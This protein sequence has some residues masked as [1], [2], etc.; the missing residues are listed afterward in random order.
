MPTMVFRFSMPPN[1]SLQAGNPTA[2]PPTG[3][4]VY[5]CPTIS[6]GGFNTVDNANHISTG[7]V[8]VGR[9][10]SIRQQLGINLWEIHVLIDPTL[11]LPQQTMVSSNFNVGDFLMFTKST[12]ANQGSLL[13]YYASVTFGNASP[14]KAELFMVSTEVTESSK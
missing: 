6:H 10:T 14:D 12:I 8:Y 7:I 4:K 5:Y 13:G 1:E 9:C 2:I 11:S 3:D